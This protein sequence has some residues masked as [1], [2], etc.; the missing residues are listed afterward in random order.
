MG[1]GRSDPQPPLSAGSGVETSGTPQPNS[2]Y[3][4]RETGTSALEGDI[5]V[6]VDK[7]TEN[8]SLVKFWEV[9]Y[10]NGVGTNNVEYMAQNLEL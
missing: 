4:V 1:T 9:L 2:E 10:R 5:G 3:T 7:L 8:R 6:T